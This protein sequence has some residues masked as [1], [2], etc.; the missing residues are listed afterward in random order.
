M[1]LVVCAVRG[2]KISKETA[3]AELGRTRW[4]VTGRSTRV[5]NWKVVTAVGRFTGGEDGGRSKG[6]SGGRGCCLFVDSGCTSVNASA[7]AL[8]NGSHADWNT[9]L[10][11][12]LVLMPPRTRLFGGL[13]GRCGT[14]QAVAD[15]LSQILARHLL[16]AAQRSALDPVVA[17]LA[18]DVS[19]RSSARSIYVASRIAR[20]AGAA[21]SR[22]MCSSD[23]RWREILLGFLLPHALDVVE[24]WQKM[25]WQAG[26]VR[27]AQK[28]MLEIV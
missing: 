24:L 16:A 26:G 6:E 11:L 3:R 22:P 23:L 2:S 12:P 17:I 20:V 4:V 7:S 28:R 10:G 1:G 13:R 19:N 21:F 15:R 9:H 5:F 27:S 25:L 18:R 8:V 14:I